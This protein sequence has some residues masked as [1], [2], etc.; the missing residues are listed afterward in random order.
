MS[1]DIERQDI[2]DE[3]YE[4][5]APNGDPQGDEDEPEPD[6]QWCFSRDAGCWIYE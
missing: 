6:G 3:P 1:D 2:D 5:H 4:Y